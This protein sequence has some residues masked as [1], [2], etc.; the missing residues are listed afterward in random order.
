[1]TAEAVITAVT[2]VTVVAAVT[3]I[4]VLIFLTPVLSTYGWIVYI[5]I[6][7]YYI[8]KKNLHFLKTS[9]PL[10]GQ[11]IRR[12]AW[13]N[14]IAQISIRTALQQTPSNVFTKAPRRTGSHYWEGGRGGEGL[15][16]LNHT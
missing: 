11:T 10:R 2:V 8:L 5:N 7:I 9:S 16:L 15:K 3:A 6:Y 1:M 12:G 13:E 14:Y 4:T